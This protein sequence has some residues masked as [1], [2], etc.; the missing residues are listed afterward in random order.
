[1]HGISFTHQCYQTLRLC[2]PNR[3]HLRLSLLST[4]HPHSAWAC[5]RVSLPLIPPA[6]APSA[7]LLHAVLLGHGARRVLVLA[8]TSNLLLSLLVAVHDELVEEA[9]R[10]ALRLVVVLR[11]L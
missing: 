2:S 9:A 1:M 10:L 8:L 3:G 5:K 11:L 4:A 6:Q 7:R